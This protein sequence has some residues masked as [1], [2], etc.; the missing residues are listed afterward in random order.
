MY[1][2]EGLKFLNLT[3]SGCRWIANLHNH[4]LCAEHGHRLMG[5][6]SG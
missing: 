2:Q 3:H 4:V 6:Q 1:L 5:P